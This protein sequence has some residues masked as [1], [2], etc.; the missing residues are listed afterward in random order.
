MQTRTIQK[1]IEVHGVII[2]G[3]VLYGGGLLIWTII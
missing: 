3:G 1:I 2:E